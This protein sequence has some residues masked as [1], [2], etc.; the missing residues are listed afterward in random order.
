MSLPVGE[1]RALNAIEHALEASE[2][3]MT[4]MFALFTKLAPRGEPIGAERLARPH[5]ALSRGDVLYLL[6]PVLATM[7]LI[8]TLVIGLATSRAS[9]CRTAVSAAKSSAV[10]CPGR[11]LGPAVP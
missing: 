4:A 1:Q 7:A 8:A 5:Q 10:I 2:P 9:A 6:I 3:R 11:P